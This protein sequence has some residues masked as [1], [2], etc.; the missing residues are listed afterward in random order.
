MRF[1]PYSGHGLFFHEASKWHSTLGRILRTSDQT[2]RPLTD[3]IQQTDIHALA[4]IRLPISESEWTQTHALYR[5]ATWIGFSIIYTLYPALRSKKYL[6]EQHNK[7]QES[8][9]KLVHFIITKEYTKTISCC[10][11]Y[12]L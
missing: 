4:G 5:P 11:D 3:N 2:L 12:I 7:A 10:M 8:E 6:L 9:Y 1:G